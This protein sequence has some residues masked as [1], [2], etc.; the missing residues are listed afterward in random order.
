MCNSRARIT[1][2][3]SDTA[4]LV[5]GGAV[6]AGVYVVVRYLPGYP[7]VPPTIPHGPRSI[8]AAAKSWIP[9]WN[10]RCGSCWGSSFSACSGA[11]FS[12]AEA[13][14]AA[15]ARSRGPPDHRRRSRSP[16]RARAGVTVL[17]TW[18]EPST[19]ILRRAARHSRRATP[20]RR[21]RV[22]RAPY[23]TVDHVCAPRIS[24]PT[25]RRDGSERAP[26]GSHRRKHARDHADGSAVAA[27]CRRRTGHKRRRRRE[28]CRPRAGR[29]RA[30]R[31]S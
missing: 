22:P 29:R 19:T 7:L 14:A 3:L 15:R 24:R 1:L 11:G 25:P 6:L 31:R 28:P 18:L 16:D 2:T 23:P 20:L 21:E 4:F 8:Q 30:A 12:R 26:A 27:P 17:E 13:A 10:S 5:A 9:S